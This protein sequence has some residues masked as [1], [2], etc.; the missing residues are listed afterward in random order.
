MSGLAD[1]IVNKIKA[2]KAKT[3]D[4]VLPKILPSDENILSQNS[5]GK[6]LNKDEIINFINLISKKSE[7]M[8]KATQPKV[9]SMAEES[10]ISCKFDENFIATRD[11]NLC[12]GIKLDGYSYAASNEQEELDL[13]EARNRFWNRLDTNIEMNIICKKEMIVIENDNSNVKNLYAKEVIEKWDKRQTAYKTS[14]Y[15]IFSTKNKTI[16]GFFENLRDKTTQEKDKK[17]ESEQ[18]KIK[19]HIKAKMLNEL[20]T[21]VLNDLVSFKP[22]LLNADELLNIFATYANM[23]PTNLKYSYDLITDCY[24]TSDVEFKKDY[25]IFHRNDNITTYARFLSV[26]AYE[27]DYISS[28]LSSSILRE[29]T[30]FMVYIHCEAIPKDKAIKK[31]RDTK[32]L[33]VDFVRDELDEFIQF[34]QSDREALILVSY[35]ILVTAEDLD[36]L[37][38]KSDILKGLLENQSLSVVKETLN[39][40]P[41]FFSFFPSRGNLNA[42]VRSLQGRNLSTMVN[43]ENDILGFKKNTWGNAP[44]TIFRHLSGSPFL[45]NF[46][47]SEN[48][49]AVGHTL[50]IGGTGYGK[51]TLM[52]FLMM[53]LYRYNIN[54]FAMDKLRGMHNFTNYLDG[55]YHDM[56]LN[57]FKLNPFSLANTDENNSFLTNW[58][59]KMGGINEDTENELA[60]IVHRTIKALRVVEKSQHLNGNEN[61]ASKLSEFYQSLSL[62]NENE[63]RPKFK[64][65]LGSIF[66]NTEDALNFKKTMSIINM[67]A[68]LKDSKLA[69]LSALYLFH[70]IKNLSKQNAKGF[71][72]FIDEL[73]DY[74]MDD[75]MRESILEAILEIRKING[76]ITMG[77]QNID[78]FKDMPKADSFISSMANYIIFPTSSLTTLEILEN[79]LRL[80]SS[81]IDFLKNC[82]KEARMVL[83]K[84]VS[85]D[86]S[87]VLDVNLARLGE[88]LRIFSSNASDVKMLLKLKNDYPNEWRQRYLTKMM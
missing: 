73:K 87:A 86:Q 41:L 50:V 14:Y 43:F 5:K 19:Y 12:M 58:L 17:E 44:V 8:F 77:L 72:I 37:N 61:Y 70:K 42:R 84:Q 20:K 6:K 88:H 45:F 40:K 62:P 71:F 29:N 23:Q 16:T 7:G 32:A 21:S 75:T 39:L 46:H 55:E 25:I 31:V 66:D 13:S 59:C 57:E 36:D 54:I 49:G 68:I 11:G 51:T 69:S 76:V 30:E 63:I 35:S 27:T 53:N 1:F 60:D 81:E 83:F 47:D 80:S 56:D 82:P 9:Y 4:N 34:L 3:D 15:L 48:E 2:K 85:L 52:Q 28:I 67:D 38:E 22:K 79:R 26:K 18:Q 10:N 78:F 33:A 65:F 64:K 74:L 24:L